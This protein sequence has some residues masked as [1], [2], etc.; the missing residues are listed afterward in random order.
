MKRMGKATFRSFGDIDP[1]A[2]SL[3]RRLGIQTYVHRQAVLHDLAGRG[4]KSTAV[5]S[6]DNTNRVWSNS[7]LFRASITLA[8]VCLDESSP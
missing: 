6:Y 8:K 2:R 7:H 1:T 5:F 4:T 3:H